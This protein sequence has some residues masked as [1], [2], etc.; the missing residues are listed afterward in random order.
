MRL[1]S[2]FIY[3]ILICSIVMLA[4]CA[5]RTAGLIVNKGSEDVVVFDPSTDTVIGTVTVPG[6]G[7]GVNPAIISRNGAA[8]LVAVGNTVHLI[9]LETDPP[10]YGHS[11]TLTPVVKDLV[12]SPFE[13]IYL[14]CG[15][16]IGASPGVVSVFTGIG[17]I[18][19]FDP[20]HL[21]A[22]SID[23]CEDET[24]VLV[25]TRHPPV[26]KKLLLA[27]DGTLSDSGESFSDITSQIANVYCSPGSQVGVVVTS[28]GAELKSF[29]LD[30]M[31][32]SDSF[33]LAASAL[34]AA[35]RF[36]VGLSG[37]FTALGLSFF[38]RSSE[39]GGEGY[40]EKLS[41]DPVTGAITDHP[42]EVAIASGAM[43]A[44]QGPEVFA[45]FV[46]GDKVFTPMV[47]GNRIKITSA[48]TGE[49]IDYIRSDLLEGPATISIVE[50]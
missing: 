21:G 31:E 50:P 18:S 7:P 5:H 44:V 41:I 23:I 42:D 32:L 35:P 13:A 25:G 14:A 33:E 12:A 20:E 30:G 15:V 19:T 24:T 28:T 8:G 29:V 27:E 11:I 40:I 48:S 9:E 6:V 39:E 22:D 3:L 46:A 16:E 38:V 1:K 4:S 34:P 37:K 10:T 49:E 2:W 17:E 47:L 43:D 36:P 26:V 45:V